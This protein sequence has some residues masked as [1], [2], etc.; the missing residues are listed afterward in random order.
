MEFYIKNWISRNYPW[1][2]HGSVVKRGRNKKNELVVF[3]HK[4]ELKVRS[5]CF[6]FF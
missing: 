6:L 4:E 3:H 5:R 2:P 1:G